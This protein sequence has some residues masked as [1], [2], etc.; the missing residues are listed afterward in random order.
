MNGATSA[1]L[2]VVERTSRQIS[3][4]RNGLA[5]TGILPLLV[6]RRDLIPVLFP[7]ESEAQVT[8][9]VQQ[10]RSRVGKGHYINNSWLIEIHSDLR[11][12]MILE[13]IKWPWSI[14]QIFDSYEDEEWV[15]DKFSQADV[16][17]VSSYLRTFIENGL[18][19]D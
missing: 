5:E 17:R 11:F 12:Q 13:C 4:L 18:S 15:E 2:Q 19:K 6:Q 16:C 14:T 10:Q 9:Q 7:R 3:Q 8:P 1:L